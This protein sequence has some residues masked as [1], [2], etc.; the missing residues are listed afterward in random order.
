MMPDKALVSFMWILI[1]CATLAFKVL[2]A[3]YDRTIEWK[4]PIQN[5]ALTGHLIRSEY[6]D[7]EGQ[8]RVKCYLEPGC[9]SINL[10]PANQRTKTCE[11]NNAT[12]ES[13]LDTVLEERLNYSH[14]AVKDHCHNDPCNSHSKFCQVGFTEKGY[15]CVCHDGYQGSHCN[16]H[17]DECMLDLHICTSN[18]KCVNENGS[19]ICKECSSALGIQNGGISDAQISASSE[20]DANHAAHH[21][22]LYF[23]EDTQGGS[24]KSGGWAARS[25]DQ[26]QWLQV[27]LESVETDIR[28]VETQGRNYNQDWSSAH[29]QWVESYKLQYSNDGVNF[30]YYHE[31]GQGISKCQGDSFPHDRSRVLKSKFA[32]EFTGNSDRDTVVGHDLNPPI[33]ARYIRFQPTAWHEHVSMRVELYGCYD[34]LP[35]IVCEHHT[36]EIKCENERKIRILSANYGRLN[37][38]STCPHRSI[39]DIECRA[40]SSLDKVREICQGQ[41]VCTL[42][43][44]S[45][46]F[47]VGDPCPNTYKYLLVKYKCVKDEALY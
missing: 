36:K 42:Q 32:H 11:L 30:K 29:N 35:V 19:F 14:H 18:M 43:S 8:C 9:V 22:R 5:K 23:Q 39:T 10:G 7:D 47:G 17:L 25:N 33:T 3:E 27:D 45:A 28:H 4:E 26:N 2:L 15:K 1:G 21:G 44:N 31:Q 6:V 41:T 16:E 46:F 24:I 13:S 20:Q 37:G 38:A 40:S 34:F 12:Y